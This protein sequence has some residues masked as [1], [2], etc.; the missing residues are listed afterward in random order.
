MTKT[1][2]IGGKE[3][4]FNQRINVAIE[5]DDRVIIHLKT[6]DF[7][8]GD[9]LVGRNILCFGKNGEMLWRIRDTEMTIGKNDVPQSF[10]DIELDDEGKFYADNVDASFVVNLEDGTFLESEWKGKG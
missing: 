9:P 6:G 8:F 3:L 4:E 1:F 10:L 5:L 2:T 7:D